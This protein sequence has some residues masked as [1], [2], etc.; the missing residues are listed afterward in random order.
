MIRQKLNIDKYGWVVHCYYAV[1]GYYVDEIAKKMVSLGCRGQ[2]LENAIMNMASHRLNTGLTFS[3]MMRHESILVVALT[4]SAAQFDNSL[5]HETDHLAKQICEGVGISL[6][7]EEASYLVGDTRQAMYPYVKELL[8][9]H[10]RML[11]CDG[12]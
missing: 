11:A 8:C 4:T 12:T 1:D 2:M 10:C 9:D 5:S 3:N 7:S 6:V